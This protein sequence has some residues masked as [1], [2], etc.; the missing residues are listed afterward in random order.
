[1]TRKKV[2]LFKPNVKDI[3][4]CTKYYSL[5]FLDFYGSSGTI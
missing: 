4:S 3:W 5:Y 2:S 1:M